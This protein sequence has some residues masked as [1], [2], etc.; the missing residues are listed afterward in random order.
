M[1]RIEVEKLFRLDKYLPQLVHE[2]NS[3]FLELNHLIL[4]LL[5]IDVDRFK[6]FEHLVNWLVL[7]DLIVDVVVQIRDRN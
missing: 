5:G 2:L 1:A 6:N 3:C 4:I 7:H